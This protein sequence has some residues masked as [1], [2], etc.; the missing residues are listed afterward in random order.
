[1]SDDVNV[2]YKGG[3]SALNKCIDINDII[4][5][6]RK[7]CE[8]IVQP[9]FADFL[10]KLLIKNIGE[11]YWNDYVK[12]AF[13]P[14]NWQSNWRDIKD[15]DITAL[16][17]V[18]TYNKTF[19]NDTQDSVFGNLR[20]IKNRIY[21]LQEIRNKVQHVTETNT[22]KIT[23]DD[24]YKLVD[25]LSHIKASDKSKDKLK[26]IIDK[27]RGN[28]HPVSIDKNEPSE[29]FP[30]IIGGSETQPIAEFKKIEAFISGL[31]GYACK[32]TEKIK[33]FSAVL[34]ILRSENRPMTVDEVRDKCFD[35]Y[36]KYRIEKNK[37]SKKTI[38]E[39]L[40]Q[41]ADCNNNQNRDKQTIFLVKDV[42]DR[43]TFAPNV[44]LW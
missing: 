43:Y 41:H 6:I 19:F 39:C 29:S 34:D 14:A 28:I 21:G 11:F 1:M 2:M 18:V 13:S 22:N 33:C 38:Y 15:L 42:L 7:A 26:R 5:E 23:D 31:K 40:Y 16:C 27:V 32:K 37:D 20:D 36:D 17:R 3:N 9:E 10:E 12:R 35:N 44:K 30:E 25:F 4:E 24:L 8:K